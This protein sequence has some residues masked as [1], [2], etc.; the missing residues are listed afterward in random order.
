MNSSS[1]SPYLSLNQQ[2]V[3]NAL[4]HFQTI[5]PKFMRSIRTIFFDFF[6]YL[7]FGVVYI[8]SYT[9]FQFS[10]YLPYPFTLTLIPSW[11]FPLFLWWHLWVPLPG[12]ALLSQ[13]HLL[14]KCTYILYVVCCCNLTLR[15]GTGWS[16]AVILY[17]FPATPQLSLVSI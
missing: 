10:F 5:S 14:I 9:S 7:F 8:F 1:F 12:L 17:P 13:H 6:R 11:H 2:N 16:S 3:S 15:W 4:K